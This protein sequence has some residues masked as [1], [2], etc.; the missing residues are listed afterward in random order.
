MIRNFTFTARLKLFR[1]RIN[2]VEH[3]YS[4]RSLLLRSLKKY[5]IQNLSKFKPTDTATEDVYNLQ[6][7]GTLIHFVK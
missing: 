6:I 4:S 1:L 7:D 5:K 3:R 2:Y